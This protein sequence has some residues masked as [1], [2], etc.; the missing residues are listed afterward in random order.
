MERQTIHGSNIVDLISDL[1][2]DWKK[3]PVTGWNRIKQ[4][5][6]TIN[7][8]RSLIINKQRLADLD[9]IPLT[10]RPEGSPAGTSFA[11]DRSKLIN[12][13]TLRS[14]TGRIRKNSYKVSKSVSYTHLTLPTS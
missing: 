8:P 2:R 10:P 6:Q 9:N 4:E 3:T 14:R 13:G 1:S 11:S 5:L 7:F 12:R